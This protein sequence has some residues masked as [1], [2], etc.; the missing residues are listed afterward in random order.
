MKYYNKINRNV[1]L[2]LRL[3]FNSKSHNRKSDSTPRYYLSIH[4]FKGI[5]RVAKTE[6]SKDL[7]YKKYNNKIYVGKE[8]KFLNEAQVDSM[9]IQN[10]LKHLYLGH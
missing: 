9:V 7:G 1:L 3:F 4:E 5:E 6:K 8:E 2:G 10:L